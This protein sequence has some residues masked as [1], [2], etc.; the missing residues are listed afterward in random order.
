[1]AQPAS[2]SNPSHE[3]AIATWDVPGMPCLM[4]HIVTVPGSLKV[5]EIDPV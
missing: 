4:S 2:P 1:M 5:I 3:A